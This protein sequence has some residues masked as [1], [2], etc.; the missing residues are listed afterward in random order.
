MSSFGPINHPDATNY[1]VG[2][3]FQYYLRGGFFID[4]DLHQGLL[5]IGDYANLA[6]IQE[7]TIWFIRPMQII[8]LPII[9]LFLSKKIKNNLFLLAFISVPVFVSWSTMAKPL[10]LGDSTLVILYLLWKESKSNY[11]LKFLLISMIFCI[12]YKISGLIIV[13]PIFIDIG[14]Y[15]F[16]N[17][18]KNILKDIEYIFKSKEFIISSLI[19][20]SLLLDRQIITGNFAYPLLTNVFNK[21]DIQKIEFSKNLQNYRDIF[22]FIKIFI[23]SKIPVLNGTIGP[24]ILVI[25]FNLFLAKF[26]NLNSNKKRYF[27]CLSWADFNV[28]TFLQWESRFLL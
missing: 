25:S 14:V 21:N 10:F 19:L 9:I 27:L 15:F 13:L 4:G 18:N 1:H 12:G 22:F 23:P 28:N 16:R 17:S 24:G 26:T 11:S 7:K 8:N 3:P 2:Y 6:F 5:G 20:I